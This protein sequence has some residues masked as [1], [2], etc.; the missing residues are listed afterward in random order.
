M[1]HC[2]L[3]RKLACTLLLLNDILLMKSFLVL[4]L[5]TVMLF[6]CDPLIGDIQT[7][8]EKE[9]KENYHKKHK[10][11]ANLKNYF[12]SITPNDLE[13]NI[14]FKSDKSIDFKVFYITTPKFPRKALFEQWDINP[15][16]FVPS[17]SAQDNTELAAETK[18]LDIVKKKL[19]WTDG[20]FKKVKQ[21]LDSANCISVTNGNPLNVGFRRIRMGMYFYNLFD[22]PLNDSLK[23]VYNDSCTYR[24]YND[25]L[26]LEFR[27]GAIGGQCFP[28]Q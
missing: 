1:C 20:T 7:T 2:L 14:E 17:S 6:S 8:S 13:V 23:K 24:F 21:F 28:D 11:I 9:L 27:G 26:V 25:T 16:D 5:C 19:G 15:Y 10:E 18:S 12:N 3:Y 4:I 22:K